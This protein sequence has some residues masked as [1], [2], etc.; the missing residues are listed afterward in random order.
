VTLSSVQKVP[1]FDKLI[2]CWND[3]W[4]DALVSNMI[5]SSLQSVPFYFFKDLHGL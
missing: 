3:I 2:S 1:N 4:F 5:Q